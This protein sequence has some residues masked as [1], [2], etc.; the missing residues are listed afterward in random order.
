[1]AYRAPESHSMPREAHSIPLRV[2]C[3]LICAICV[4]LACFLPSPAEPELGLVGAGYAGPAFFVEISIASRVVLLWV[5][6]R[7]CSG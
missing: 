7:H 3:D 1:M 6:A 4:E 2:I 5:S